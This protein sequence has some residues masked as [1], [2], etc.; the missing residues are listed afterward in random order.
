MPEVQPLHN[1]TM[2]KKMNPTVKDYLG[3]LKKLD[4]ILDS[5]TCPL[6]SKK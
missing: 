2:S 5:L 6:K 4:F 3:G 1:E